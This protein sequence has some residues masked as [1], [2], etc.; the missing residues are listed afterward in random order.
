MKP[1]WKEAVLTWVGVNVSAFTLTFTLSPLTSDWPWLGSFL[2]FNTA[3][4]AGLTWVVMPA[5]SRHARDWFDAPRGDDA[6]EQPRPD[7]S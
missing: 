2:A 6:D 7:P 4:V 1:R 5:L 3:M